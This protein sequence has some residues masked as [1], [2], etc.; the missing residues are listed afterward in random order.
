MQSVYLDNNA[1]T[2]PAPKVCA[3]VNDANEHLWGNPSSIHRFGQQARHKIELARAQLASLLSAKPSEILFTSG[4]TESNNLAITGTLTTAPN[5]TLITTNI[6]HAAV[7]APADNLAKHNINVVRLPAIANGLIDPSSLQNAITHTLQNQPTDQPQTILISIQFANNETG[8]IQPIADLAA[9]IQSAR[10]FADEQSIPCK[11]YFHVDATQAVGKIPVAPKALGIDLL[12]LA[13]H[14]FHGPKGAGALW[15][16]R[17]VR[18]EPQIL[19]GPQE[20]EKRGGTE[21]T[22]AILGLGIAAQLAQT[23]LTETDKIAALQN[24]RDTFEQS[25]INRITAETTIKPLINCQNAPRLWN[26][27]NIAFTG[28]EA[29]AILLALSERGVF[30]SAGAA[31]SSGSLEPSP[32]LLAMNIPE[33]AAHGSVRFS[34]SRF[35]TQVELDHAQDQIITVVAKLAKTYPV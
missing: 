21:N 11:I 32:I 9:A 20:R 18:Y 15:L 12:T 7:A 34:L 28:L 2:Q 22:P 29:E 19:G 13:G 8:T 31:C 24:M 23:F 10:D 16:R 6:E 4:G 1:T 3:T 17:G 35:T 33:P 5:P 14:K 27:A 30:A 25:I 26:T